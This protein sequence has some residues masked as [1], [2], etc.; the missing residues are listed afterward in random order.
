MNNVN[1]SS[2]RCDFENCRYWQKPEGTKDQ[3]KKAAR[4]KRTFNPDGE[5]Q[6]GRSRWRKCQYRYFRTK[7]NEHLEMLANMSELSESL[8]KLFYAIQRMYDGK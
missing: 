1:N 5:C 3:K 8:W 6:A 7:A 4:N 2:F